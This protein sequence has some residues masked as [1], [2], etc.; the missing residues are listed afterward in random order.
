LTSSIVCVTPEGQW[1]S[2]RAALISLPSPK[3]VRYRDPR[4]NRRRKRRGAGR[5]GARRGAW[6]TYGSCQGCMWG[7]HGFTTDKEGN[8]Y[9]AEVRTGRVQKFTPRPGARPETLVG[10]PWPGVW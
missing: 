10:K 7:V 4:R 9:T 3:H 6:G 5:W 8:L 2:T 1:I